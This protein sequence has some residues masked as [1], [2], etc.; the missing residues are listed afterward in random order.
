MK[1]FIVICLLFIVYSLLFI[2]SAYADYVLPYPSYMPGNKIYRISRIIDSLKKYW[3]FGN[4]AQ[5]KYHQSLGDKYLVESKTLFE[6]KQYLLASEALLRSDSYVSAITGYIQKAK[7]EGIDTKQL[8]NT[9][10]EEMVV[11]LSVL[12]NMESQLPS[13]FIW[14]PEK[15]ESTD[16]QIEAMLKRS[17]SLR[18][19]TINSIRSL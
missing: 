6:Y 7:K 3:Y 8:E 16:L 13:E 14:K 17:S 10:T 12:K 11:H 5:V 1:K 9:V 15:A 2:P 18:E 4:L 19:T